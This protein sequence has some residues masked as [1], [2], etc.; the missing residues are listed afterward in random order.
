ML[1]RVTSAR[2]CGTEGRPRCRLPAE[3][4]A[5]PLR[6]GRPK[7]ESREPARQRDKGDLKAGCRQHAADHDA[8]TDHD[9]A[10]QVGCLYGRKEFRQ[11]R[12]GVDQDGASHTIIVDLERQWCQSARETGGR[13][14]TA[15][16]SCRS[17]SARPARVRVGLNPQLLQHETGQ[18]G[19]WP[20]TVERGDHCPGHGMPDPEAAA[21]VAE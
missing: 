7:P 17:A 3:E 15:E 5:Q 19:A 10:C 18:R 13:A 8:A 9:G 14:Y 11:S 6:R 20:L 12:R 2:T 1:R 4:P 21:R 16:T